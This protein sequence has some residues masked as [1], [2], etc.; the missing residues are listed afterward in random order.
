MKIR[1]TL[2]SNSST[3]SFVVLGYLLDKDDPRLPQD[4]QED[5]WDWIEDTPIQNLTTLNGTDAGLNEGEVI[6]GID[7]MD[8]PDDGELVSMDYTKTKGDIELLRIALGGAWLPH[9][10]FYG[11]TRMC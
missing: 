10:K 1:S 4:F 9:P 11:G 8:I 7:L 2:V 3:C 6:I 5:P